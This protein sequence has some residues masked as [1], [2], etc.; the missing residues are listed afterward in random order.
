MSTDGK[1]MLHR[2]GNGA[3]DAFFSTGVVTTSNIDRTNQRH[4]Q[5]FVCIETFAYVAVQINGFH[6]LDGISCTFFCQ[7][8]IRKNRFCF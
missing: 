7:F 3:V 5:G 6:A 2:K 8:S 1:A 4:Y